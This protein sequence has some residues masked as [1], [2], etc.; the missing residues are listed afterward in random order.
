ME[1]KGD[2]LAHHGVKGMRWGFRKD[3][4][5]GR[6]E[7]SG[8]QPK[9]ERSADSA[10]AQELK[11]RGVDS[12]SNEELQEVNT[13]LQLERTYKQMMVGDGVPAMKEG[14]MYVDEALKVINTASQI[15]NLKNNPIVKDGARLI[16][17]VRR[18]SR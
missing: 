1:P 14:K 8:K 15:Y 13:R 7:K 12:L 18:M 17:E 2:I 5:T 6:V 3:P 16:Q 4:R 9:G 10:R 11:K